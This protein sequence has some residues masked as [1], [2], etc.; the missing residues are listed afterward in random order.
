MNILNPA[1]I[2]TRAAATDIV[3]RFRA[4]GWV[5]PSE[6]RRETLAVRAFA[7]RPAAAESKNVDSTPF[8]TLDPRL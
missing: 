8:Q 7:V 5:P 4:M 3:A 2:Y 6:Q 1:F